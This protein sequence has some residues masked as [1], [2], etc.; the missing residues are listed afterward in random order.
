MQ[1]LK[2][3]GAHKEEEEEEEEERDEWRE[4]V[5]D[6]KRLRGKHQAQPSPM[7]IE[8]FFVTGI[9]WRVSSRLNIAFH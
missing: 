8:I 1:A 3:M 9:L 6:T 7:V 4:E 2:R 5:R